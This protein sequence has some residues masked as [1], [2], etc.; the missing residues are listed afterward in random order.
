MRGRSRFVGQGEELTVGEMMGWWWRAVW[1]SY[2]K[3]AKHAKPYLHVRLVSM[4][5]E[6][7]AR[8]IQRPQLRDIWYKSYTYPR[9]RPSNSSAKEADTR[10]QL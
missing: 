3:H 7:Y 5:H 6:A 9:V 8:A 1:R 4:N 2:A 10:L